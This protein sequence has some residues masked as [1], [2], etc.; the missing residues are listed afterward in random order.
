MR[1]LE[2]F[3]RNFFKP[4][5][6]SPDEVK[7]IYMM[8]GKTPYEKG[9]QSSFPHYLFVVLPY[10]IHMH[11]NPSAGGGSTRDHLDARLVSQYVIDISGVVWCNSTELTGGPIG[12]TLKTLKS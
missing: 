5:I 8:Y 2:G 3:Y 1:G 12:V 7:C 11:Q 4:S 6:A 10:I 9:K